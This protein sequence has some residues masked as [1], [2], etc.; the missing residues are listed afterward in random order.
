MARAST[1]DILPDDLLGDILLFSSYLAEQERTL[2][3]TVNGF[4]IGDR[5]RRRGNFAIARVSQRW[6][7]LSIS[8]G[9]LWAHLVLQNKAELD[10]AP[11]ALERLPPKTALHI[12]IDPESEDNVQDDV[13]Y[14][15]TLRPLHPESL[16]R[17]L[18]ALVRYVDRIRTMSL[19]VVALAS[20]PLLLSAGIQY[21]SLL[22][23]S[24]DALATTRIYMTA[25]QLLTLNLH[26]AVPDSENWPD[27]MS[28]NLRK[29]YFDSHYG[30]VKLNMQALDNLFAHCGRLE[31][32]S[33]GLYCSELDG[34]RWI[35][36][37]RWSQHTLRDF[38][39]T[40]PPKDTMRVLAG[41]KA[42]DRINRIS[43]AIRT[44][45]DTDDDLPLDLE[46][47]TTP[48][49]RLLIQGFESI[50]H[51]IA[52]GDHVEITSSTGQFREFM[53][54]NSSPGDAWDV[55]SIWQFLCQEANAQRTIQEFDFT[56]LLDWKLMAKA[57]AVVPPDSPE[58]T[59]LILTRVG[60]EPLHLPTLRRIVFRP[61]CSK[62]EPRERIVHLARKL[63]EQIRTAQPPRPVE[64]CFCDLR[65]LYKKRAGQ[66]NADVDAVGDFLRQVS[67]EWTV[68]TCGETVRVT[69]L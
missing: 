31:H 61:P 34:A 14:D 29:M 47:D 66:W 43:L 37:G 8:R 60:S 58:G 39:S 54:C 36:P 64:I 16:E 5:R 42:L 38:S 35:T 40:M 13:E 67:T 1:I 55:E 28:S 50:A 69:W 59:T 10:R 57:F 11:F 33:I 4:P 7:G 32:L 21:P 41:L 30:A 24:V 22:H 18:H 19:R 53:V 2:E 63:M 52:S 45:D 49:L 23:L 46:A 56:S 3:A 15:Y 17:A 68:C 26:R 25:P 9:A 65:Q 51:F 48:L 20:F 62:Y 6:R 27:I 12:H 44:I